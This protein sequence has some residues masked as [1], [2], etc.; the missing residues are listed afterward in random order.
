MK[1]L[2]KS[3]QNLFKD[4]VYLSFSIFLRIYIL[5]NK[6]LYNNILLYINSENI[7]ILIMGHWSI[8]SLI[9]IF[10]NQLYIAN[11]PK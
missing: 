4:L 8:G 10:F 1:N 2:Q 3:F 7:H 5:L 11:K 9:A 6:N